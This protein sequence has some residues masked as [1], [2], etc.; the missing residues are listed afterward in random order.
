VSSHVH[1]TPKQF[2][3]GSIT[4]ESCHQKAKVPG[5]KPLIISRT[6]NHWKR[7]YL[8]E[9]SKEGED[10]ALLAEDRSSLMEPG[11]KELYFRV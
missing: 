10:A 9:S 6:K 8:E 2:I 4:R 1:N 3:Y 5:G 7:G 11:E